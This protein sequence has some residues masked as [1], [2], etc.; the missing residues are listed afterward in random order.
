MKFYLYSL[1]INNELRYQVFK[2]SGHRMTSNIKHLINIP[3]AIAKTDWTTGVNSTA[4]AFY[5]S[6]QSAVAHKDH[7]NYQLVAQFSTYDEFK[8]LFP[9]YFL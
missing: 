7:T 5:G 1:K 8:E 4:L 3:E 9:E 6:V 2:D